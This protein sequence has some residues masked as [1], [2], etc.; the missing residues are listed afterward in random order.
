LDSRLNSTRKWKNLSLAELCVQRAAPAMLFLAAAVFFSLLLQSIVPNAYVTLLL[1]AT[2]AS[3]WVGR[4]RLGVGAGIVASLC[5]AYFFLFPLGSLRV[6]ISLYAEAG[7]FM[8]AAISVGWLSGDRR[9]RQ[10]ELRAGRDQYRVLLDGVRDY[11]VFLLDDE[12]RVA[13]W[14][15]G[16]QRIEGFSA[17]E[18]LGKPTSIFY[19]SEDVKK[20]KPEEL[21]A[22]VAERGSVCTEGWR[23]RKDGSRYWAAVTITA[24]FEE[25]GRIKGYA[26]TLRDVTDLMK[27]REAL[28]AKEEELRVVVESAPDAVLMTDTR[29]TIIFVNGRAESMFGYRREEILGREVE[30]LVPQKNRG[31]HIG[32]RV[33]YQQEPHA[34]P[35]GMGLDL[36]G[37]KKDGTEFPV[38]IS[39]SPVESGRERRFIASVRDI[40]ERR[41]AERELQNTRIQDLAQILIRDL[42]GRIVRWNTG[43]ERMYGYTRGEAEGTIAHQLLKTVFPKLLGT[44][45]AELLRTGYWEGELE[46]R[47]KDGTKIM[48]TGNWVLHKDKEGKPWRVLESSTDVTALKRAEEKAREL[49]QVLEQQ[50]AD[51]T[52]AKAMIEAQTQKIAIAAKMSALGEMAGGMAHEINNPMG[53]IHARASDLIEV[54]SESDTVSSLTV[55]ETMEKIRNTASRVTKI[56]MGLRKFA[57]ET[58]GDPATATGVREILEETLPFCMERLKQNSV[59]L[60][61]MPV[62]KSLR[63]DCRPTEISQVLLNLL[64]N[65]VDAVQPLPEKWVELQVKNAGKD[66]EI[67]VTDSGMGIPEKIRD[68]LGQPFFTTKVVGHGT[69]LG[70]SI[71]KGI[72]EAHGGRLNLDPECEH[73]RFVVT[74]PKTVVLKREAHAALKQSH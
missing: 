58:R 1:L 68:K 27:G 37:L 3:G 14:N 17:E 62:E 39:L 21:L 66:V 6:D 25:N 8:S 49:N 67:L 26:K 51:L 40:T 2:A 24:L 38:E 65:A 32:R 48:V 52:L 74:L 41:V 29:G 42:D 50:N 19:G 69:G 59:E 54:A 63:I 72:V 57:R 18:I 53:I 13:T 12:G 36:H 61:V 44:I 43:M 7:L 34:R 20:R 31:A 9:A 10:D 22:Q 23:A 60:R 11:A 47:T 30:V 56:T 28:E 45:E 16:A 46:H 73:T 35:M 33:G 4:R 71:S 64:N 15:T 70:L 55:V 5:V